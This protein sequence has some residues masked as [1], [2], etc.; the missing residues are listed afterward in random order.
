[1]PMYGPPRIKRRRIG[2]GR[3]NVL[4]ASG[5]ALVPR[6]MRRMGA[7]SMVNTFARPGRRLFISQDSGGAFQ[8]DPGNPTVPPGT[9]SNYNNGI[10]FTTTSAGNII[11]TNKVGFSQTFS[12]NQLTAFADLAN[13]Y[14]NFRIKQVKLKIELS[15]NQ[16]P[17]ADSA[18]SLSTNALP[19]LHFCIDNDDATPPPSSDV[20]LEYSKSRSVRLGDKP[21]YITL[22]PRAQG[23]I[24]TARPTVIDQYG[25]IGQV[26]AGTMLPL[27][28]WLDCQNAQAV[29]HYAVKYFLENMPTSTVAGTQ[30]SWGIYI[31]PVYILECKNLH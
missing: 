27:N 26:A 13:L 4:M 7:P 6:L 9:I 21:T 10:A 25:G 16:A 24:I 11:G 3:R 23:G 12:F 18:G 22:T 20:V 29:P 31:T 17:G 28:T 30:V 1:M 2:Y 19:I 14:D 8:C 15:F 5:R